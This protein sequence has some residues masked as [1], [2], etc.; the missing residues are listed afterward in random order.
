M[1]IVESD[2]VKVVVDSDVVKELVA[3]VLVGDV[4]GSVQPGNLHTQHA[5]FADSIAPVSVNDPASSPKLAHLEP[6]VSPLNV[7]L[8]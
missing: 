8:P 5:S 2:D 3:L 4:V 7:G 1:L 6:N